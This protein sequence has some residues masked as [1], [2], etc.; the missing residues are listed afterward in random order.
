MSANI[1][2]LPTCLNLDLRE[3]IQLYDYQIVSSNA[4]NKVV[5]ASNV[6]SFLIEGKKEVTTSEKFISVANDHFLI[7]KS[8]H[9]LMT[10]NI[11]TN[12]VYKSV[13]LFFTDEFITRLLNRNLQHEIQDA[14]EVMKSC[15]YDDYTRS[16]VDS[17][18]RIYTHD[19][20]FQKRILPLKMEE[21]VLYLLQKNGTSYLDFL[22]NKKSEQK[23][24]FM[25]VME[26][27]KL[28]RLTL[29]E[30]AFLTHMSVSTF[31]REF[32]KHY[33]ISPIKWFQNRRLEHAAHLL[34][35]ENAR[36]SDIYL[37]IGYDSLSNFIYAFKQKYKI[38]PKQFQLK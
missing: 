5:L 6:I 11:S 28:K 33:S 37:D 14:N 13:L 35:D 15:A 16:F 19:L 25:D 9:C 29:K 27:N 18:E 38:T 36:P 26:A 32:E 3:A 4:N 2:T 8:G 23:L 31:K 17:L 30:L 20:A 1:F 7:M 21:L 10:E 12:D 22:V 34:K 24:N